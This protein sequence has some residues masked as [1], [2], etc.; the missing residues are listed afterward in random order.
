ML[1]CRLWEPMSARF[2]IVLRN[3]KVLEAAN[4]VCRRVVVV[5]AA[6]F[7]DCHD[8]FRKLLYFKNTKRLNA[9]PRKCSY[10][11]NTRDL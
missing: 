7:L 11:L 4:I 2:R 5:M 9:I 6:Q 1:F 8:Y 10:E 3:K